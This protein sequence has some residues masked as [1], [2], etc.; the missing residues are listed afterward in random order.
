MQSSS[1]VINL[2]QR[3]FLDS[4]RESNPRAILSSYHLKYPILVVSIG[5]QLQVSVTV[6][7][8]IDRC[9]LPCRGAPTYPPRSL[10]SGRTHFTGSCPASA[11]QYAARPFYAH[12]MVSAIRPEAPQM[13]CPNHSGLGARGNEQRLTINVTPSP[14]LE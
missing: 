5:I 12:V 3:S 2:A 1:N 4:L 11:K 8:A 7:Q 10:N 14:H 6:G 9:F 13:K